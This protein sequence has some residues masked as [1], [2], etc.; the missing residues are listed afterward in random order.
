V[1]CHTIEA[2]ADSSER[3]TCGGIPMIPFNDPAAPPL[4]LQVGSSHQQFTPSVSP[5]IISTVG[6]QAIRIPSTADSS[7]THSRLCRLRR[8]RRWSRT[9]GAA[10][11][12]SRFRQNLE[13]ASMN[14][15][16]ANG[17]RTT[18][19]LLVVTMYGGRYAFSHQHSIPRYCSHAKSCARRLH[20]FSDNKHDL[21]SRS[22]PIASLNPNPRC[23]NDLDLLH[24]S[25]IAHCSST[26]KFSTLWFRQRSMTTRLRSSSGC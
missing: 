8:L 7:P 19:S 9:V 12:F 24:H 3:F 21:S 14:I 4:V 1:T 15:T 23:G 16:L 17:V 22:T 20:Q 18:S 11:A 25:K 5:S 26:C 6:L 13:S 2:I 10:L